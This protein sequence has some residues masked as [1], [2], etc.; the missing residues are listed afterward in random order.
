MPDED[1]PTRKI[2]SLYI[3]TED[4]QPDRPVVLGSGNYAVVVL[5]APSAVPV[6]AYSF[7]AIK[8]LRKDT[9]SK[10]YSDI[11]QM[12]FYSEVSKTR[13]FLGDLPF[14][15]GYKGYGQTRKIERPTRTRRDESILAEVYQPQLDEVV[16]RNQRTNIHTFIEEG[17]KVALLGEFYIMNAASGT[18]GDFL[19][20]E[21][22]WERNSIFVSSPRRA[23]Q[24]S[25]VMHDDEQLLKAT[26]EML[27]DQEIVLDVSDKS[28]LGILRAVDKANPKFANRA[29]IHLFSDM[30]RTVMALHN[31]RHMLKHSATTPPG[32][33]DDA[34]G[35]EIDEAGWAH[36][37]IKPANFLMDFVPPHLVYGV[38]ATDL[39]FV[40]G[41]SDAG[42]KETMSA[43][44]DPGVL[45]L[46]S[47]LYR[48]P[49]Q[50]ESRYEIQFSSNP[51]DA[52]NNVEFIDI[53]DMNI[54]AGDLFESDDFLIEGQEQHDQGAPIRTTIVYAKR[55]GGKFELRLDDKLVPKASQ[56]LYS[57]DVVK[58]TG[59]HTD[60]FSLGATLYL[61]A[62]GGK[63]PEKFFVKYLEEI[64]EDTA[65]EGS[66]YSTIYD[67][68][69][70]IAM[71]LC[72]QP[73][74]GVNEEANKLYKDILTSDD[75][76]FMSNYHASKG[77][78]KVTSSRFFRRQTETQP[79]KGLAAYLTALRSNPMLRYYTT[80][81]NGSAIPFCILFEIVRLMVRDKEHSYV[82]SETGE[83]GANLKGKDEYRYGYFGLDLENVA[84]RCREACMEALGRSDELHFLEGRYPMV[85]DR[86]DR[87]VFVIRL[88]FEKLVKK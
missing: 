30:I 73:W 20:Q 60:L 1:S 85:A 51:K 87:M 5:A 13:N 14:L 64:P 41:A 10:I 61:M 71:S 86:A 31:P 74:E 9:E 32:G 19:L 57:G 2:E 22:G 11:G 6:N 21:F 23:S 58:L 27:N 17:L 44:K 54:S 3:C 18:L 82:R 69:F 46:G 29:I 8:F 12:R 67:S 42:K 34:L 4:G 39:G 59:Q 62:S 55:S 48:A 83:I 24:L 45:A 79:A 65:S 47:Y 33:E 7:F 52:T 77:G 38:R 36:R 66:E 84:E 80:N 37:D 15:V 76:D 81:K 25:Q 68:C 72:L 78:V 70:K 50:R 43:T 88:L 56:V 35:T 40:I 49:E 26:L 63:N 16:E 53:G 28:G 75:R